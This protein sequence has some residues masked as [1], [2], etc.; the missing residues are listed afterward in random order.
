MR[1]K[2]RRT[3]LLD[4][5]AAGEMDVDELARRFEVSASTI[6]RDLQRLDGEKAVRRTYG[7]AILANNPS[8]LTLDERMAVNGAQKRAIARAAAGLIGEGET[9]ILDAGS[10]VAAL[11]QL[12]RGRRLRIVTNNLSLLPF[13]GRDP[14]L[15]LIVLG[16][17]FRP[18]SMSTVG[19]LAVEAMRR[20]TADHVFTSADGIV[21]EH[22]LCEASLD[23]IALKSLMMSQ[24]RQV[25]VLADASKLGR[26][27]QPFWAPLPPRFTLVT[28]AAVRDGQRRALEAAGA[29]LRIAEAS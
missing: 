24:A 23:Q 4:A 15:E 8:E 2:D 25:V 18:T 22:G 12:L 1:M 21:A 9:V 19:V 11:G 3:R 28:D 29:D 6:R 14:G 5:L 16:G 26:A 27:A 20:I 17:K 13:L 10:T 7:G